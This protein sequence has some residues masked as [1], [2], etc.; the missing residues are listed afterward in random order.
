M[1]MSFTCEHCGESIHGVAAIHNGK[2]IHHRCVEAYQAA[3]LTEK[4]IASGLLEGLDDT[5]GKINLA[6]LYEGKAKQIISS[7]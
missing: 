6:D 2:I 1:G 5:D 7:E 4:W 3:K